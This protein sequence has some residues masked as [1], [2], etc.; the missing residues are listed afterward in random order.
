VA[1]T[2]MDRPVQVSVLDRLTDSPLRASDLRARG[3]VDARSAVGA[4]MRDQSMDALRDAVRRDLEWLLNTRRTPATA[5]EE[6]AELARS[7]YHYGL[8]DMTTLN[9]DSPQ[10][11]ELLL[12]Y[13]E[14][15][16]A[17]FEPRLIGVRVTVADY[18]ARGEDRREVRF[19]IEGLLRV[20]PAP[21]RIVFDTVLEAGGGGY[22]V[23]DKLGA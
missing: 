8:P 11:R 6:L 19:L 2:A 17:L 15:T 5:P 18:G 10:D 21:E 7:V 23:R 12:R 9:R 4:T 14:E 1:K 20:D 16:I 22:L 13:V 3:E